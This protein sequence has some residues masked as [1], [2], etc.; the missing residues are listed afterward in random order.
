MSRQKAVNSNHGIDEE[1][2]AESIITRG[3]QT[4]L[5]H[6]CIDADGV[7]PLSKNKRSTLGSRIAILV[8][9]APQHYILSASHFGHVWITK[10]TKNTHLNPSLP[11]NP[12]GLHVAVTDALEQRDVAGKPGRENAL[13]CSHDIL[14]PYNSEQQK[15]I[16]EYSKWRPPFNCR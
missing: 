12:L 14:V 8:V 1:Q 15:R 13:D 3:V 11:N 9:N 7:R 10:S 2:L 5:P 6:F 4:L 16:V